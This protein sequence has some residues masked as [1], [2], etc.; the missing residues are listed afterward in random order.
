MTADVRFK[1]QDMPHPDAYQDDLAYIHD[2]GFG[3]FAR[4]S[5]PN[6]LNL[7]RKNGINDGLVVDLGCGS[8][9]WAKA[10]SDAGYQVVGLDISPAMI[11]IARRRVPEA[12]FHVASFVDFQIPSCRAVTALGEVF[13][14][15]FDRQNSLKALRRLFEQV[16]VA[17]E[18]HG[19]LV[20][21]VVETSR[22]KGVKQAFKEGPDWTCLVEYRHD[23]TKQQL[24]RRI[25]S[26]RKVG[27]NYRRQEEIHVQQLYQGTKI[28]EILREI[29]FRVQLVR[30]YG[31]YR[32]P[33]GTV[34]I[35]ARKP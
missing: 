27:D 8:G 16:F 2:T 26:F 12:T 34:G 32:L 28:A 19:L 10:L 9:I 4:S 35:V 21:D 14:Y 13:N 6:L 3:G 23:D 25:V 17:L 29:G 30:S 20:F 24:T 31:E 15:L 5:A 11:E 1:D 18:P 33:Q 7:F 22:C